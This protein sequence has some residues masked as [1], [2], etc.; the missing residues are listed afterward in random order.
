[1]QNLSS[2]HPLGCHLASS[3]FKGKLILSSW[4]LTMVNNFNTYL[5][6]TD[7]QIF[8]NNDKANHNIMMITTTD[9]KTD[10]NKVVY[11]ASK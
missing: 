10:I 3:F 6:G 2:D 1:M 5:E 8:G 9:P 11:I 4:N 7:N